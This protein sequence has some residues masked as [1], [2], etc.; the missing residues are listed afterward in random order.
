VTA[1]PVSRSPPPGLAAPTA[2]AAAAASSSTLI[3]VATPA[4]VAE[5]IACLASDALGRITAHVI[6]LR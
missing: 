3:Y 2:R 6:T 5:V 1:C 4:Q